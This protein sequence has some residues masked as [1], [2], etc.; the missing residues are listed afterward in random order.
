MSFPV[1]SIFEA[2][3]TN[4]LSGDVFVQSMAKYEPAE[5]LAAELFR[6]PI[7]DTLKGKAN[8]FEDCAKYVKDHTKLANCPLFAPELA[9][10]FHQLRNQLKSCTDGLQ[11]LQTAKEAK[12]MVASLVTRMGPKGDIGIKRYDATPGNVPEILAFIDYPYDEQARKVDLMR[13]DALNILTELFN[14]SLEHSR[15]LYTVKAFGPS[16]DALIVAA[17]N[18]QSFDS[19]RR[20]MLDSQASATVQDD[21]YCCPA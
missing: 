5:K 21:L 10:R 16:P 19:V 15:K 3:I 7:P 6:R 2:F 18:G 1:P 8:Y 11:A 17:E 4:K 14:R 20:K 13:P 9:T 12:S